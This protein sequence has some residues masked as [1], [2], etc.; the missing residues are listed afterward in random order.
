MDKN[1]VFVVCGAKEHLDTLNFSLR[2]LKRFSHFSILVVT[3]LKRNETAI[4]HP[5]DKIIDIG[6]T[7]EYS[8]HQASIYLKTGLHRFLPME[9][10]LYCYLDTDVVALNE[11][12]NRV[13]DSFERPISF[14]SD[15]CKM[16]RFSSQAVFCECSKKPE[17][18]QSLLDTY[19]IRFE[20]F[21]QNNERLKTLLAEWKDFRLQF[22][23]ESAKGSWFEQFVE[24][25]IDLRLRRE[26]LIS[27]TSQNLPLN[28]KMFNLL[29][30]VFPNYRRSLLSKTW[31]DT[32]GNVLID[33]GSSYLQHM[34]QSGFVFSKKNKQWA[35]TN[36]DLASEIT[37]TFDSFFLK[38]GLVFNPKSLTWH[39]TEGE[40]YLPDLTHL[41]EQDTGYHYSPKEDLW[42]DETGNLV[43][44]NSC[45]HLQE[46]IFKDFGQTIVKSDWQHW[47]GGVFVF[48][49]N[50]ITFLDTWHKLTLRAFELPNWK[51]RDQ[52]TLITT[53][54]KFGLQNH[55]VLPIKFNFIADYY[56]P[57]MI[58]EGGLSFRINTKKASVS[59]SFL[60]I[61]HHWA[62][63]NWKVWNDVENHVLK[64]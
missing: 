12:I 38:K 22:P 26:K 60:H 7:E 37:E 3:D 25:R 61:Y 13:F 33:E 21:E 50:S 47:N 51:I 62:D 27:L 31:K 63:K 23:L 48:D 53:V 43:F 5:S 40:F 11:E 24:G 16:D 1:Y 35:H 39:T 54:W 59:P 18:L 8:H 64:K 55:P 29:F 34:K 36:G 58:Y 30:H 44:D 15:H 49:I 41:V 57:T 10:N 20:G 19:A 14:S 45:T 46:A 2:A 52:G 32:E 6:V 28:T 4:N 17:K 9:N 42:H 56:H